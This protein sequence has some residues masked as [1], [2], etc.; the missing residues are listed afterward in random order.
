[1]KPTI[2]AWVLTLSIAATGAAGAEQYLDASTVRAAATGV[3]FQSG[4]DMYRMLPGK[5]VPE[6][7]PHKAAPSAPQS[8]AQTTLARTGAATSPNDR[9]AA[10][11]GP[12]AVMLNAPAVATLGVGANVERPIAAAVN[13]RNGRIVLVNPQVKLTGTTPATATSLAASSGGTI[14]YTSTMDGSAVITYPSVEHAQRAL[15]NLQR[16]NGVKQASL[17]VMQAVIEPM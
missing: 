17:V 15:A 14:A 2:F 10:R 11:I 6:S 1:M 4:P 3:R 16:S 13:E 12:Y 8:A 5:V 9:V 7:A